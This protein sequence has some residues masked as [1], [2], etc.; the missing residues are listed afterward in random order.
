MQQ[1]LFHN[2]RKE[3]F[4]LL[5]VHSAARLPFADRLTDLF[6]SQLTNQTV[7]M[8]LWLWLKVQGRDRSRW[9]SCASICI[10]IPHACLFWSF[11]F[12]CSS[13]AF[14]HNLSVT[15]SRL[16]LFSSC[17]ELQCEVQSL[18]PL[19]NCDA[20]LNPNHSHNGKQ[21]VCC[22]LKLCSQLLKLFTAVAFRSPS[23]Q[24]MAIA[25]KTYLFA[26]W[27]SRFFAGLFLP[28]FYFGKA[29][30]LGLPIVTVSRMSPLLSSLAL[31]SLR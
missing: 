5:F 24:Q 14:S 7:P 20:N 1:K 18:A 28:C 9:G 16:D 29:Y 25:M 8:E 15:G 23:R 30:Y 13:L 31:S 12:V 22:Q 10:R 21:P 3:C 26:F 19:P 4:L 11:D 27:F 6:C 2:D 17:S